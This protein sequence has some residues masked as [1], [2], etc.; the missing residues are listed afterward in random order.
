VPLA[1]STLDN[2]GIQIQKLQPDQMHWAEDLSWVV[3]IYRDAVNEEISRSGAS[4][5]RSTDKSKDPEIKAMLH[6]IA[7]QAEDTC[8][9]VAKK[10]EKCVGY[11]L[12]VIK[13]YLA[14]IPS[15]VGYVNGL[16]ILPQ[17]RRMGI[18]QKLLDLGLLWFQE[19][20]LELVELYIASH[21]E[22]AKKFWERNGYRINEIVMLKKI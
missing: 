21:N 19:K 16:Y 20:K 6:N 17:Y 11:F 2:S 14:E 4:Q 18:G 7:S 10:N 5:W 15:Q 13:D 3:S 8:L 1:E 12:G 9:L 22:E